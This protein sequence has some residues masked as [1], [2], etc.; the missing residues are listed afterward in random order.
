MIRV[1]DVVRF[2]SSFKPF[3][4][5]Y[6]NRSPGVVLDAKESMTGIMG[7]YVILWKDGSITSE[8]EGYLQIIEK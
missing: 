1:G 7:S 2:Y 6:V 5:D 8:R 4:D 3:Q